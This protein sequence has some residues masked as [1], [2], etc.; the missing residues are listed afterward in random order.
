MKDRVNADNPQT[1]DQ[2]KTNIRDAIVE[3][4]IEMC[5]NVLLQNYLKRIEASKRSRGGHLNDIVFYV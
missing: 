5:R 1:L 3:I 4:L 2:L